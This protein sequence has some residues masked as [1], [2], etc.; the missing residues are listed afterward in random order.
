[1][2]GSEEAGSAGGGVADGGAGADAAPVEGSADNGAATGGAPAGLTPT[3]WA[4]LTAIGQDLVARMGAR[5]DVT[6][7]YEFIERFVGAYDALPGQDAAHMAAPRGLPDGVRPEEL[8]RAP[9]LIRTLVCEDRETRREV[10]AAIGGGLQGLSAVLLSSMAVGPLGV[11]AASI[12]VGVAAVLIVRG[13][14]A[15]CADTPSTS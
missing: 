5:G 1:M 15:V 7:G 6:I 4:E 14:D 11:I 12:A 9:S 10:E 13:V 2:G 8:R 3:E